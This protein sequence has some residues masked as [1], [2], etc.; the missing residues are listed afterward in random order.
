MSFGAI[1]PLPLPCSPP[2]RSCCCSAAVLCGLLD[3]KA[4]K[5]CENGTIPPSLSVMFERTEALSLLLLLLLGGLLIAMVCYA[6]GAICS[7][8]SLWQDYPPFLRD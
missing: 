6:A 7:Y 4:G 8:H 5:S 2:A 3:V 1:P